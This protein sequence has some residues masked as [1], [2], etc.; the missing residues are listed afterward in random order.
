MRST[1]EVLVESSWYLIKALL[2][3]TLVFLL[4]WN[5]KG[6]KKQKFIKNEEQ[7][8]QRIDLVIFLT[9]IHKEPDKIVILDLREKEYYERGHIPNAISIEK[10]GGEKTVEAMAKTY[11]IIPRNPICHSLWQS[12]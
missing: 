4:T 12:I 8:L 10:I 7:S 3:G 1:Q 11:L 9:E 5:F 6:E 2:I